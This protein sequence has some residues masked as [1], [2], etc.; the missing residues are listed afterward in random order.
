MELVDSYGQGKLCSGLKMIM[1]MKT[2]AIYNNTR[3][4]HNTNLSTRSSCI[5]V[6]K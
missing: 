3:N 5:E 2:T 1:P 4:I 6:G